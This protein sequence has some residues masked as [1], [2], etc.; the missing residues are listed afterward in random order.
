MD[1]AGA[2][3]GSR[4]GTNLVLR[5]AHAARARRP[6]TDRTAAS[7]TSQALRGAAPGADRPSGSR[8]AGAT[9]PPADRGARAR[10]PLRRPGPCG[11]PGSRTPGEGTAGD[12]CL[13]PP[14]ARRWRARDDAGDGAARRA[15]GRA[16][17]RVATHRGGSAEGGPGGLRPWGPDDP[18]ARRRG[19]RAAARR[20]DIPGGRERRSGRTARRPGGTGARAGGAHRALRPE[21]AALARA[22]S[23]RWAPRS[24]RAPARRPRRNLDPALLDPPAVVRRAGRAPSGARGPRALRPEPRDAPPHSFSRG[25]L[26]SLSLNSSASGSGSFFTEMLGHDL[27]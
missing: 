1:R 26:F 5:G 10:S 14:A 3:L 16:A 25:R 19:T 23:A 6:D 27:E 20:P 22:H 13:G 12:G 24:A 11:L 9:P 17:P 15:G 2:S 7:I 18:G 8:G 4:V 21:R